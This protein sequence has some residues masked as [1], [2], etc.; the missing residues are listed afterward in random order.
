VAACLD[1][2]SGYV[3]LAERLRAD[4]SLAQGWNFG[5]STRTARRSP[6]SRIASPAVGR[7]GRVEA[8]ARRSR[9]GARALR[10][11]SSAART[12]LGWQPRLTLDQALARTVE[13]YRAEHDGGD[14]AALSLR[15]IN[16]Y[17]R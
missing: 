17:L 1:P 7:A 8:A 11:D 9:S 16:H 13:W 15:Q 6:R 10:L 3:L 14:V 4:P 2:L 5:A 12:R